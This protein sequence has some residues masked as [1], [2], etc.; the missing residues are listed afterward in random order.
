MLHFEPVYSYHLCCLLKGDSLLPRADGQTHLGLSPWDANELSLREPSCPGKAHLPDKG[1]LT[2]ISSGYK[3]T[4]TKV[5]GVQLFATLGSPLLPTPLFHN[6]A[7]LAQ[8]GGYP[9]ARLFHSA[10]EAASRHLLPPLKAHHTRT[11]RDPAMTFSRRKDTPTSSPAAQGNCR[12][13]G[14]VTSQGSGKV[15]F[16]TL[17]YLFTAVG[18]CEKYL[19]IFGQSLCSFLDANHQVFLVLLTNDTATEIKSTHLRAYLIPDALFP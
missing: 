12:Q 4:N 8:I 13:F 9:S 7:P 19:S 14:G 16:F 5:K 11:K 1:I 18:R 2:Q 17:P 10:P 6:S 3:S 15:H